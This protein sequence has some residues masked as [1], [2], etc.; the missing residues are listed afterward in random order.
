MLTLDSPLLKDAIFDMCKNLISMFKGSASILEIN[1]KLLDHNIQSCI[2]YE[3]FDLWLYVLRIFEFEDKPDAKQISA[4]FLSSYYGILKEC[5]L[6]HKY[7]V[8]VSE[9]I[10]EYILADMIPGAN[11]QITG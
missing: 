8:L 11:L 1:F 9:I 6:N 7:S 2:D 4:L 10:Q 3:L 5:G